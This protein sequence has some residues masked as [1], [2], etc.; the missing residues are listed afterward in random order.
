MPSLQSFL[1][2]TDQSEEAFIRL[3]QQAVS[4]AI[5]QGDCEEFEDLDGDIWVKQV[6]VKPEAIEFEDDDEFYSAFMLSFT[7]EPFDEDYLPI[8]SRA[9]GEVGAVYDS[10]E[11]ELLYVSVEHNLGNEDYAAGG[12]E[13]DFADDFEYEDE[14]EEDF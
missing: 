7:Y 1:E 10:G 8:D 11:L 5:Q 2:R 14:D 3:V 12:D 6:I 13:D 4:R 9:M